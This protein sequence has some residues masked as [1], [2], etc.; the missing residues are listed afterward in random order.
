M[1]NNWKG[2]KGHYR[3]ANRIFGRVMC[4]T[5]DGR[6]L[7]VADAGGQPNGVEFAELIVDAANTIQ[8]CDKLPSE[9]LN[10]RNEA[11][12]IIREAIDLYENH[13]I[14]IPETWIDNAFLFI[15]QSENGK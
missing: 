1:E 9:L 11:I 14:D 13:G 6:T 15:K 10:E 12:R 2:T 8:Q 7:L 5:E 3:K 4:E